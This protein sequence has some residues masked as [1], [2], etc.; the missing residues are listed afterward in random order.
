M[1]LLPAV[2]DPEAMLREFAIAGY[3]NQSEGV[4]DGRWSYYRWLHEKTEKAAPELFDLAADPGETSNV[5]ADRPHVAE[6]LDRRL[7]GF[8]DGLSA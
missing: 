6:E 8:L 4:R 2:R 5:I 7:T 3:R 1:S